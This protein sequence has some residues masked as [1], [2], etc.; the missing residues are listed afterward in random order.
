MT[1]LGGDAKLQFEQSRDGL[2]VRLP[3]QAPTK[4]F[5]ALICNRAGHRIF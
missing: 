1:L 2:H 3:A 4:C 5:F